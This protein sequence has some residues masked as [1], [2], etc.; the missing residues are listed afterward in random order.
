MQGR[1][2]QGRGATR[3][4]PQCVRLVSLLLVLMCVAGRFVGEYGQ[5]HKHKENLVD[6]CLQI[7]FLG[8]QCWQVSAAGESGPCISCFIL[9]YLILC[10]R[11]Y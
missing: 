11:T 9:F 1:E 8:Q 10:C 3:A 5:S 7:G 2:V 6:A 4:G